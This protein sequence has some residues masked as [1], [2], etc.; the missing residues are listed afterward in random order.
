MRRVSYKSFAFLF[1]LIFF[2]LSLQSPT[3]N[4]LRSLTASV[5]SPSWKG[6][7]MIKGSLLK[8][9]RWQ[10]SVTSPE[11]LRE[12]AVLKRENHILQ[13]QVELLKQHLDTEVFLLAQ[14]EKLKTLPVEQEFFSRRKEELLYL[15]DRQ[16]QFMSAK[17]IF[18][19]PSVWGSTLW[20]NVG[21]KNNHILDKQIVA[22][23]SPVVIGTTVVGIVEYVGEKRSRVRLITDASLV[24]SVRAVRG[25]DQNRYL[26][27]GE[28]HGTSQPLWRSRGVFLKGVGFNYDFSDEEGPARHIQAQ[29]PLIQPGDV[30]VTTGMD[31]VFPKGLQV[32]Y[33]T[34]V[35]PL[36][37]GA[38]SYTITAKSLVENL[39]NLSSVTIL[40]PEDSLPN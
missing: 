5:I 21:H 27:K 17:V 15:V 11:V 33:V 26:A 34:S 29:E 7:N 9:F 24:P 8:M 23:N 12:I 28:L 1:F 18:R 38:C 25:E 31:G 4:K 20:V 37:E 35:D 16:T 32:A 22:K 10:T 19:E 39:D 6:I 3:S 40:P 30:L 2:V 14:I 36:V 13:Q